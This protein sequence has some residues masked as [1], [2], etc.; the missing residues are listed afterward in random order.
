MIGKAIFDPKSCPATP[1]SVEE[2]KTLGR[3]VLTVLV[4]PLLLIIAVLGS[5][6]AG[7]ATPTESASVGVA[8]AAILAVIKKR[9]SFA[10]LRE[11]TINT[12]TVTSMVFVILL[13]AAVF[14]IVFRMMGG[15]N[16]VHE[17][18]SDLPGGAMGALIVVMFVMF[19]LG[20]ILDTFEII[21]IVIPITAPVL[22]NLGVDP[23]WLGVLV[24]VN[25][26][27]SFMTPPF[28]FSL[29]YLRGVAPASVTTG[30]I[31]KGV[32]PFVFLQIVAITLL[33]SFP[34]LTTWLPKVIYN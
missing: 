18:L 24:G 11:A 22:L 5:I 1:A 6:M 4:P 32:L 29:F 19:L 13:G 16:L 7:I 10:T 21:F 9:F 31:Y 12:A 26:Q 30:M 34:A 3:D 23:L 28:G 2:R 8:G 33:L 17:V 15:D 25:L 14:S 20:F 27:T